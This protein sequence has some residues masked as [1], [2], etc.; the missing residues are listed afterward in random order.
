MKKFSKQEIEAAVRGGLALEPF[1]IRPLGNSLGRP[2]QSQFC[3]ILYSFLI[4]Y[5]ELNTQ[6]TSRI[7]R[8]LYS[9]TKKMERKT[10]GGRTCTVPETGPHLTQD[11]PDTKPRSGY[12]P[13][14]GD[15]GHL[16]GYGNPCRGL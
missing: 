10:Q 12:I 16:H 14:G 7:S 3:K 6:D 5:L 9:P 11:R 13:T 8:N 2:A 1:P 15:G 4:K